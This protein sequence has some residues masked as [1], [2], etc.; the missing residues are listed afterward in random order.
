MSISVKE[1]V[2]SCLEAMA[3]SQAALSSKVMAKYKVKSMI[4][5]KPI[6]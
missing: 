2:G 4:N 1:R 5:F 6:S 3:V